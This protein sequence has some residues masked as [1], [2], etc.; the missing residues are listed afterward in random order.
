MADSLGLRPLLLL[1][2]PKA[3][4]IEKE[5]KGEEAREASNQVVRKFLNKLRPNLGGALSQ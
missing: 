5:E 4:R 3:E 2:V 1:C